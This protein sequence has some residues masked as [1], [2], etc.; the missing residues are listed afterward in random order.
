MPTPHPG[1]QQG[2]LLTLVPD[3]MP[4]FC[5]FQALCPFLMLEFLDF[6]CGSLPGVPCPG[7]LVSCE[8]KCAE[9]K[10]IPTL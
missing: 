6:L 2:P 8:V 5:V 1:P 7:S 9:L 10:D 4:A 3:E